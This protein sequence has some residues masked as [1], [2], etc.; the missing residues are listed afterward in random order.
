M[1]IGLERIRLMQLWNVNIG[2]KEE[3]IIYCQWEPPESGFFTLNTDGTLQNGVGVGMGNGVEGSSWY[4][5]ERCKNTLIYSKKKGYRKASKEIRLP[6][7]PLEEFE[8]V[9]EDGIPIRERIFGGSS[10]VSAERLNNLRI[11]KPAAIG[12]VYR[13]RLGIH[14]QATLHKG[15]RSHPMCRGHWKP[16]TP[17]G[18][19]PMSQ[20]KLL[21]IP[22]VKS[23][24]SVGKFMYDNP[25]NGISFVPSVPIEHSLAQVVG[26]TD[27]GIDIE[28][29]YSNVSLASPS[30]G[31]LSIQ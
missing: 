5:E 30:W 28:A 8:L 26:T 17:S 22:V 31:S 27:L 23:I 19:G 2:S 29:S 13:D 7:S 12:V 10:A 9:S 20:L 18:I 3:T 15:G 21:G 1:D 16:P 4:E 6:D 24:S 11:T 14:H 25:S